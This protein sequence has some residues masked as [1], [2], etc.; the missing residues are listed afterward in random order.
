MENAVIVLCV[1]MAGENV[2]VLGSEK[3]LACSPV[4]AIL[5][6]GNFRVSE[7]L[8]MISYF[9]KPRAIRNEQI[10]T[11]S[12]CTNLLGQFWFLNRFS[13]MDRSPQ[14]WRVW[15]HL[16]N[17]RGNFHVSGISERK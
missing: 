12:S 8:E 1:N 16:K 4:R 6:E 5:T 14:S 9:A 15:L 11:H 3:T 17:R 7:I 2:L 10:G 13:I